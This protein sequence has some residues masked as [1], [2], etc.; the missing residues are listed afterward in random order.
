MCGRYVLVVDT[1][2]LIEQFD[3]DA[4]SVHVNETIADYNVAPTKVMP[5]IVETPAG[6]AAEPASWGL[7][8]SWAK[9]PKIGSRMINAR[10]ETVA[11]KPAYRSSFAKKRCLVP[12]SG[13]YEWY[14]PPAGGPKQPFYIHPGDDGL[15]A[16]AGLYAWWRPSSDTPWSVSYTIVTGSA[17]GELAAIHDRVPMHVPRDHWDAWL[18][19]AQ[20]GD[21]ADLVTSVEGGGLRIDVVST[22]VN[23]VRNNGPNLIVP[24]PGE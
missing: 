7:V 11:E 6:R 10:I 23:Q 8:P 14:T 24:I 2:T 16:L 21:P 19:P 3:L 22:Q 17:H 18:D 13:Y 4:S 15:L 20:P 5:I 9:D 12:A 1:A